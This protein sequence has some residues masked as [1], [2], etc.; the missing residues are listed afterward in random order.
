MTSKA[1]LFSTVLMLAASSASADDKNV[2]VNSPGSKIENTVTVN[3][4]TKG[5][6]TTYDAKGTPHVRK[7]DKKADKDQDADDADDRDGQKSGEGGVVVK[8]GG[9]T[10]KTKPGDKITVVNGDIY[11]NGKKQ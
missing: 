11:V 10:V 8:A 6:V 1:F 2:V 5:T 9:K 3:G 4:R 7:I